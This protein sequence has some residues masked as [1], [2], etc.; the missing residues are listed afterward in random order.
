[1]GEIYIMWNSDRYRHN[2]NIP[3]GPNAALKHC[4]PIVSGFEEKEREL[5]EIEGKEKK[6]SFQNAITHG[7][8]AAEI[9]LFG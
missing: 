5:S 8:S 1:M 3:K 4:E 6:N 2:K 7:T 9:G